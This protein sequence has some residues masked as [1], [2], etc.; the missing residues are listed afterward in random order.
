MSIELQ[1]RGIAKYAY[2]RLL[3]S[4]FFCYRIVQLLI[5]SKLV[6]TF[7]QPYRVENAQETYACIGEY[8]QPQRRDI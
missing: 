3:Y 1:G 5:D 8:R 2:Y 7:Y 6:P 4:T